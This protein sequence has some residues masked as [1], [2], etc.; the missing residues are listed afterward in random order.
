MGVEVMS[1]EALNIEAIAEKWLQVCGACDAGMGPCT[2]PTDEDYRTPMLALVREVERLRAAARA[3]EAHT[4][5]EAEIR[6]KVAQ[7]IEARDIDDWAEVTQ[8]YFDGWRASTRAAADTARRGPWCPSPD[9]SDS[10]AECVD[11]TC[12]ETI[13]RG[14]AGGARP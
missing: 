9:C 3:W 4:C 7:E 1:D 8:R 14:S 12:K 6:E 5:G 11:P 10:V 2:H 13:A